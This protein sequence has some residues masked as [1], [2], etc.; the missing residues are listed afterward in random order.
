MAQWLRAYDALPEDPGSIPTPHSTSPQPSVIEEL[1]S[2]SV[3]YRHPARMWHTDMHAS[4]TLI[5]VSC[6][7]LI[8]RKKNTGR[9]FTNFQPYQSPD[10]LWSGQTHTEKP[11]L[12]SL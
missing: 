9:K 1:M 7:F 10:L 2:S 5:R 11:Q 12:Y 4:K 3:L 8:L 6:F